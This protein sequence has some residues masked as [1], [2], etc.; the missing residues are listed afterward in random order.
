LSATY[1]L[2]DTDFWQ[3]LLVGKVIWQTHHIPRAHLWTWPG[4]GRP[5]V[6][7][8]W[9]FRAALW[10]FWSLGGVWG[11]FAFRWLAALAAF[12]ILWATARRMGARGLS[13]LF[14][15]VLC[16]V[17]YRYRMQ[18]RP[19]SLAAVLLA[20][21]IWILERTRARADEHAAGADRLPW[22]VPVIWVWANLH[23][24]FLIGLGLLGIHL[25]D[26]LVGPLGAGAARRR[27]PRLA[28]VTAAALAITLVHPFG[29]RALTQPFEFFR[30]GR[31]EPILAT[32]G[33]LQPPR[34][35]E[36]L[37]NGFPLLALGWPLLVA[38]RWRRRGLDRVELL[39]LLAFGAMALSSARFLGNLA[40]VAVPYVAR[41]LDE[42]IRATR[43]PRWTARASARAGIT[44]AASALAG[45]FEWSAPDPR[46]GIGI[47]MSQ[48]PVAGCDW[49]D[50][51]GVRGRG[52]NH[53]ME[54]GYLL[55]RFWPDRGR[56]PFMDIHQSGTR[57]DRLLYMLAGARF[58]RWRELDAKH[59][60]DW[61]LLN[62]RQVAGDH[63]LDFLDADTSFGLVFVDDAAALY[64][65]RRGA[66]EPLVVGRYRE[67]PAGRGRLAALGAACEADSMRRARVRVELERQAS[68]SRWNATAHSLLAS[69]ALMEGRT[70]AARFHLERALDVD[71]L[72]PRTH[73]RLGDLALAGGRARDALRE[74]RLELVT[75]EPPPGIDLRIGSAYESLGDAKRARA[76]YRAELRRDPGNGEAIERLN[77]IGAR[78][79]QP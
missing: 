56:L 53:F 48:Y 7:W 24:S 69:I 42:W 65:K 28:L 12:G 33:E 39:T 41:D 23:A 72:I 66:L 34:I 6:L 51:H 9:G 44:V 16:S 25:L 11:L 19:E 18:V 31:Q 75:N 74:Y 47:E 13:A 37:W 67:I 35:A 40:L 73:E 64:L 38:W 30:F 3:H 59:R 5:E 2:Y 52:F 4:Y 79:V 27:A 17:V 49:M 57:E 45:Y 22:V 54:G 62:R 14:V 55:W 29:W 8:A 50:A 60:F 26:A 36:N 70:T 20:V 68:E 43:W 61:V 10:P 77:A 32:I 63:L 76:H 78:S 71:P 46:P 21:E 58:A 15:V 1:Q